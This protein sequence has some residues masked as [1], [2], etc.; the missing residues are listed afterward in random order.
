MIV[1]AVLKSEN[2]LY[3]LPT[4]NRIRRDIPLAYNRQD[5]ENCGFISI[6]SKTQL[7]QG[8]IS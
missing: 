5:I 6:T 2:K 8:I 4:Q 1:K 7:P 3:D